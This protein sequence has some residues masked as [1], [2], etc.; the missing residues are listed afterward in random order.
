[1]VDFDKENNKNRTNQYK[2]ID[3]KIHIWYTS[4]N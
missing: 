4:Y 3:N 2:T 1:M